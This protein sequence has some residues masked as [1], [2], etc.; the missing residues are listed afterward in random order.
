MGFDK[1]AGRCFCSSTPPLKVLTSRQGIWFAHFGARAVN[2]LEVKVCKEFSPSGLTAV[3][4]LGSGEVFQVLMV[5]VHNDVGRT[6]KVCSP[7]LEC[8]NDG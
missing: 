1:S 8:F 6:L 2:N 5:G 3:E 7:V 4:H